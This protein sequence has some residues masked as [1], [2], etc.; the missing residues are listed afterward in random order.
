MIFRRFTPCRPF[1]HGTILKLQHE[2]I[3]VKC[4]PTQTL[5]SS[6]L[7]YDDAYIVLKELHNKK[8]MIYEEPWNVLILGM[9]TMSRARAFHSMPK[10]VKYL[11]YNKWLDYRAFQKVGKQNIVR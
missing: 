9:D 10:L 3:T 8:I 2:V 1:V 11:K 6:N 7:T 4:K 5:P